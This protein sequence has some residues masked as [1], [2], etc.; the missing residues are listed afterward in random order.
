VS[1]ASILPGEDDRKAI[2]DNFVALA[3]RILC[4]C[5]PKLQEIPNLATQHILHVHSKEMGNKSE[6]V[7]KP[8]HV[9]MEQK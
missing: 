7:R 6:I 2:M 3:G 8:H 4:E 5:I 1:V 9:S